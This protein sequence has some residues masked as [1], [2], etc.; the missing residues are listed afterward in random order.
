MALSPK[1]ARK[2]PASALGTPAFIACFAAVGYSAI[3]ASHA[4]P[5]GETV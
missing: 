3:G 4:N 5:S 2:G 1:A